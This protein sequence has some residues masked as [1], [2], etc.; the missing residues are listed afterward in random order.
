VPL[1]KPTPTR[2]RV[3][4]KWAR[5]QR[6]RDAA[7]VVWTRDGYRCRRCRRRVLRAGGLETRGHIHHVV[8]RSL[9]KVLR[10]DPENLVLLCGRCHADVHAYRVA[11]ARGP[12]GDWIFHDLIGARQG[13]AR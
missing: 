8:P 4:A 7:A 3:A 12:R 13:G 9:S 10:S 5:E 2:D 11:V 1:E 6:L